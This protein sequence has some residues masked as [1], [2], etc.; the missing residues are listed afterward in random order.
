[1]SDGTGHI[2]QFDNDDG[3]YEG[4]LDVFTYVHNADGT[5][6]VTEY[7]GEYT[8]TMTVTSVTA[9]KLYISDPDEGAIVLTRVSGY[10]YASSGTIDGHEYINLGLPSGTLW[11][12]MNV[13]ATTETDY[14]DYFAWGETEGYNSG[15]TNFSWSTYKWCQGS[16]DTMTKYCTSSV[17]GTV[18][19]ISE[20]QPSDD[21]A[22]AN[23]GSDW[24]MPS[25]EQ[26]EELINSSYTT[27]EWVTINGMN[28]RKITSKSNGNSI[29]LPAAGSRST[30]LLSSVG[31]Y[32]GYRSRS[33]S[34]SN[35]SY[36][37]YIYFNSS[38]ISSSSSSRCLGQGVRPVVKK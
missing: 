18:D 13:G 5:Y 32:G 16:D 25:N 31:S 26:C 21:A 20:L 29:F 30:T 6:T 24:Q 3:E 8:Y 28:G 19:G 23:W 15:K 35:S 10:T 1:M 34:T 27:T 37:R 22:T 38:N 9:T 36:G 33:L 12:T 17:Y 11:A 4:G 14:G 7:D 2:W